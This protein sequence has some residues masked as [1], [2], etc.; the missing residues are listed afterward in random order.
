MMLPGLFVDQLDRR[1]PSSESWDF[2]REDSNTATLIVPY[3]G[4][5]AL[6][7]PPDSLPSTS[8]LKWQILDSRRN[9]RNCLPLG[10]SSL[11]PLNTRR[12]STRVGIGS[13]LF[14]RAHSPLVAAHSSSYFSNTILSTVSSHSR[15]RSEILYP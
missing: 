10:C 6:S 7:H 9:S 2:D 15:R 12:L 11:S 5:L 1:L 8:R 3:L 4:S 13:T 14:D